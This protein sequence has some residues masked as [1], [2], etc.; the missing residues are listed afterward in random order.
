ML[1]GAEISTIRCLPLLIVKN[2]RAVEASLQEKDA[3]NGQGVH[4][5]FS[6]KTCRMI[7]K[8]IPKRPGITYSFD[9]ERNRF[10]TPEVASDRNPDTMPQLHLI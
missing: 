4:L 8:E 1:A 10:I 6:T 3:S 5:N 9:T 7:E 2:F